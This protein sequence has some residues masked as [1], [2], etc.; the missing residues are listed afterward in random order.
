MPTFVSKSNDVADRVVLQHRIPL[1]GLVSL[2]NCYFLVFRP[3]SLHS[4]YWTAFS[5]SVGERTGSYMSSMSSS[6]KV[7]TLQTVK[8]VS[9]T[10]RLYDDHLTFIESPDSGGG[11]PDSLNSQNSHHHRPCSRSLVLQRPSNRLHNRALTI[12]NIQR[13]SFLSLTTQTRV[14]PCYT[15]VSY[16]WLVHRERS[17]LVSRLQRRSNLC[18]PRILQCRSIP[19]LNPMD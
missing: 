15:P 18:P 4:Q 10:L 7:K 3:R 2:G 17:S 12:S 1:S 6:G 13:R 14:F 5:T 16:P 19:G 8:P 11:T 9:G